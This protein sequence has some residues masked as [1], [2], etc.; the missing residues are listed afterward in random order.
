M[1]RVGERGLGE[2]RERGGLEWSYG[3]GLR[4]RAMRSKCKLLRS[5]VRNQKNPS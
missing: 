4:Q 1:L 3:L 5:K 2:V